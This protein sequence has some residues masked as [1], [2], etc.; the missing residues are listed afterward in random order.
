LDLG[1]WVGSIYL[2]SSPTDFDVGFDVG[3]SAQLAIIHHN[4]R[5]FGD[6]KTALNKIGHDEMILRARVYETAGFVLLKS[7]AK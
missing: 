4:N 1:R 3:V 7:N 6:K 5:G 2:L